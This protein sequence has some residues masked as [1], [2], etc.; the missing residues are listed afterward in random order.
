MAAALLID[1]P[2]VWSAADADPVAMAWL[3]RLA[4]SEVALWALRGDAQ[5]AAP[6]CCRTPILFPDSVVPSSLAQVM[7]VMQ[8]HAV[9]L[10]GSWVIT[11]DAQVA[12]L[13]AGLGCQGVVVIEGS[14]IPAGLA[15]TV[16]T[17]RNLADA[18]RVMIPARGGCWHEHATL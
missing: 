1:C 5:G 9:V 4:A 2:G 13:A 11:A 6:A 7:A 16:A 10:T 3:Q 14:V 18:P 17:A 15:C 12:R 8:G